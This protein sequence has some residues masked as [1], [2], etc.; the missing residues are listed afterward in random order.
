MR[1]GYPCVNRTVGCSAGRT[2]RLAS[3]SHERMERAVGENLSCLA[4]ILEYNLA[5]GL[6]FFRI[7]SDTVPFASHPVC[8]FE[9][10]D[11]FAGDFAALGSFIR[12]HGM[13]V[14][15]H[16]DQFVLINSPDRDVVRRSIAE[17]DYHCR[18][19]DAMGLGPDAKVQIHVGGLYRDRDT[20]M[21][22]FVSEYRSLPGAVTG[23]MVIENDDRL[24]C[25]ADCLDL[26]AK[27]GVPVLFDCFHHLCLNR[28]EP[29]DEAFDSAMKTWKRTD[30]PPMADYSEQESG[31]RTGSH[32]GSMDETRFREFIGQ[33]PEADFDLML[34]IKDKE[35]S[36]IRALRILKE[37]GRII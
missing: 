26:H 15:M 1:V 35:A 32:A 13:R 23:R 20:A 31:K 3:Y 14:S 11:R 4:R 2:F 33:C 10:I 34:E 12:S 25:L 22:R 5:E 37:T 27:T 9:W 18:L 21:R 17:L 28:G 24:F 6:L 29:M 36:A 7:S 30:G 8:D 16:P 19:L